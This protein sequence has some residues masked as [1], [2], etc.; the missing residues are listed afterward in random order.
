MLQDLRKNIQGT[1]A[2]IIVGLI[3]ISFSIFG[4]ESI[5]LG[6][7]G[8]SV[9]EVNGEE[10]TPMELQQA[11]NTTKRR[12]IGMMGDELDPALLDDERLRPQALESL[13]A[14]KL[15]VLSAAEMGLAVS[16]Q[17]I[18]AMI[19]GMEQ[20]Q[21]DGKFSPE[22]YRSLLSSSGF[23]PA[24][25]KQSLREDLL[26][27]QVRTGLAGSDFVTPAELETN[28]RVT[29]EQRD[30]RYL[31]L[32]LER[33]KQERTI[34][35][36]EIAEYYQA[37]TNDF[38]TPE[39][40]TLD[41][42]ELRSQDFYQPVEEAAL[43]EAYELEKESYA[44]ATENRV[45]HILFEHRDGESEQEHQ[46]RIDA[47]LAEL[48][49]GEAFANVAGKYSDD[50]GS[51]AVGGD[52]GFSSGEAFPSEMEA[53][54]AE[55]EVGAVSDPVETD[56]GTH[57]ILLTERREGDPPSFEEMRGELEARLQEDEARVVLLRTVEALRD[58]AFNAE[59]LR[60]P[61]EELQLSVQRSDPVTR[62]QSDGLF[63]NAALLEAAF[64]DELL[65]E[66][67]NSDV[68]E[69]AGNHFVVMH[70]HAYQQPEIKPLEQVRDEIAAIIRDNSA[71]AAVAAE[72]EKLVSQLR[73]GSPLDELAKAR[74]LEWHVELGAD[75]GNPNLP[76]RVL[77][78]AFQLP[79]PGKGETL[80]DY[81]M[82]LNGDAQV[83]QLVRVDP[84]A[85]G[86][87]TEQQRSVLGQ[88]VRAEFGGLVDTEYRSG[89]RTDADVTVM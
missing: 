39:S 74:Q 71:R 30:V 65:N 50:I 31:T 37:H 86:D 49:A 10:I 28:A 55:L 13:I 64:S 57:L 62:T 54:I 72:A 70:V 48:D 77:E 69:L 59:D 32:P 2:K 26:I 53:A 25:F 29:G 6:G 81:V 34:T 27:N 80:S 18:G 5:L 82:A 44:Y 15:E 52:L 63:A 88:Q 16:E 22:L 66:G 85:Y 7:G 83:L 89:L 21:V 78:R 51:S 12:L 87:L 1:T 42:I 36:Q 58:L 35:E 61:A 40:V 75:R 60:A 38:M 76:P 17:E 33:F 8:N 46:A 84:G 4:I 3:V 19:S 9:A 24:L 47:A 68:I 79:A 11:V 41:Y 56:A 67:H 43:R 73:Q 14:R 45:S 20:F 23:T